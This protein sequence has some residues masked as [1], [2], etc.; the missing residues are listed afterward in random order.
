MIDRNPLP[1]HHP[2]LFPSANLCNNVSLRITQFVTQPQPAQAL[3][4]KN[5][6]EKKRKK[7]LL[8]LSHTH[9]QKGP[10]NNPLVDLGGGGR[11]ETPPLRLPVS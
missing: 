5:E 4:L 3:N 9:T 10:K 1:P 11:G 7:S 6:K 2:F 8:F